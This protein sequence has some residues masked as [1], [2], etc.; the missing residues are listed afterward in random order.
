MLVPLFTF[1]IPFP[2]PDLFLPTHTASARSFV[3]QFVSLAP[4]ITHYDG[5]SEVCCDSKE[6]GHGLTGV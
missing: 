6:V 3:C 5:D 4:I 1:I 2:D